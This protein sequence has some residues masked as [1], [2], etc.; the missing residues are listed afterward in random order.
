[1]KRRHFLAAT[2]AA[3]LEAHAASAQTYPEKPIRIIV[4][5]PTGGSAD[6]MN[7]RLI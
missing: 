1:M 7:L 5:N 6:Y 4:P 3:G 2:G